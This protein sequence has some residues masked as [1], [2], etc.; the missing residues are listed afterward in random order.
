MS[1]LAQ[2]DSGSMGLRKT[3]ELTRK[4]I[5]PRKRRLLLRTALEDGSWIPVVSPGSVS[6]DLDGIA[7]WAWTPY[8]DVKGRFRW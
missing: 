3:R 7:E 6:A 8:T 4:V 5:P 2:D 1:S